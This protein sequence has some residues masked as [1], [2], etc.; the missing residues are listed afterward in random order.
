MSAGDD[1][2]SVQEAGAG[3]AGGYEA[4]FRR[5]KRL[6]KIAR[7]LLGKRAQRAVSRWAGRAGR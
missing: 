5:G 3:G 1:A 4:D 7:L 6:R 2:S